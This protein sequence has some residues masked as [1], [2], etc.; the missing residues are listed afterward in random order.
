[1]R[2]YYPGLSA[3]AALPMHRSKKTAATLCPLIEVKPAIA[4]A[5]R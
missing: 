4:V 2:T 5:V 3:L 1:M